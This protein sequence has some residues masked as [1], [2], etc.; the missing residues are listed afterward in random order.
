MF[1]PLNQTVFGLAT[2]QLENN[3]LA[4]I[5][6]SSG[7]PA[8]TE[9]SGIPAYNPN[10]PNSPISMSRKAYTIPSG[11]GWRVTEMLGGNQKSPPDVSG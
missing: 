10:L 6:T 3:C 9:I 7:F 8:M 2:S 1:W 11:K 4:S 5:R